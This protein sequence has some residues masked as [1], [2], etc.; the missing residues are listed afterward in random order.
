MGGQ[1]RTTLYYGPWQCSREWMNRCERK[2]TAQGHKLMGCMWLA[3]IKT[4]WQGRFLGLFPSAAGGR[5]AI[6][7]CCCDYPKVGDVASRREQWR[8]KRESFRQKWDEEFGEW[9]NQD[10]RNYPGHHIRDLQH[11]GDPIAEGNILPAPPGVH[12]VFTEEYPLCYA[13]GGKWLVVGPDRPY[14]D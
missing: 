1:T 4:D 2:C 7:Q 12:D 11:G 9:P 10:G 8:R 13:E 5:L 6:T 3:D 14:S